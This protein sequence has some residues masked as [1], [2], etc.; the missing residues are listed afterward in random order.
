M[1][2]EVLTGGNAAEAIPQA[3]NRAN[4]QTAP[5]DVAAQR[6][7]THADLRELAE[8]RSGPL[9]LAGRYLLDARIGRGGM[10]TVFSGRTLSID[11]PV[12]IK[13][14]DDERGHRDGGVARFIAEARTTAR[15]RSRYIVDVLDFGTTLEGVIYLV[16]ELLDGEDLRQRL[17]REGPLGWG[18]VQAAMLQICAGLGSIHAADVV[19]RD[20]KPANCFC[21]RNGTD[22]TIKLLDFGIAMGVGPWRDDQRATE[23]GRVVGTPEYMSPEQALGN[24]VDRR[25]DIYAAGVIF[26]ELLTGRVP[27]EGKSATGVIAQQ[28]YERPPSLSEL[29]GASIHPELEALYAKTLA[30]NPSERPQSAAELARMIA[31]IRIEEPRMSVKWK[32]SWWPFASAATFLASLL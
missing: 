32:K 25:S 3:I 14:L 29:A 30:K 15:V 7:P 1:S 5:I 11:R 31:G 27:F 6:G 23:D 2:H 10:A 13:V 12:A 24:E 18:A 9:V 19:H 28:I 16:M 20:L 4:D 26:G 22:E 21:V 17:R 8:G